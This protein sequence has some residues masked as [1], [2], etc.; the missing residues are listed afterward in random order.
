MREAVIVSTARTPIGRAYRGAFNDTHGATLAGHAVAQALARAKL[1]GPEVEDVIL[2]CALQQGATGGNIARQ[3]AI[4][5]GLPV[6]S[7]GTTIDRQCSSG[8][9]AISLATQ[10]VAFDGVPVAIGGGL[11][12]ISL[13][14]NEHMNR[15]HGFD[16]WLQ[17]HKPEIYMPMIDTA[18]IVAQ[19]YQITRETQD[20]Y[21]LDWNA[22]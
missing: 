19:R 6:T 11:D 21:A 13:V 3:A 1:D 12:S 20:I 8:L 15:W 4:R 2:G 18:E 16:E 10:R 22:Q 5:A 7:A 17:A 14:Q 9:Q